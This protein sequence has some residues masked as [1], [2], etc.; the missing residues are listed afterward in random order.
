MGQSASSNPQP[1]ILIW[2]DKDCEK[3][4]NCEHKVKLRS[5]SDGSI[6]ETCLDSDDIGYLIKMGQYEGIPRDVLDHFVY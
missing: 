6:E 5:E 2:C 4:T 3:S 1:T